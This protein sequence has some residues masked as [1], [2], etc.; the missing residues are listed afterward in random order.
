ML[1]TQYGKKIPPQGLLTFKCPECLAVYKVTVKSEKKAEYY[2][3]NGFPCPLCMV[4]GKISTAKL[5]KIE[6]IS[7]TNKLRTANEDASRLALQQA[8][9][10]A[11]TV[12]REEMITLAPPKVES[13]FGNQPLTLP[14]KT[15]EKILERSWEYLRQHH[16]IE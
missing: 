11:R 7:D 2:V 16:I 1:E 12:P 10:F 13:P 14:K 8:T 15:Y 5:I 9:E 4:H 6:Q 3:K